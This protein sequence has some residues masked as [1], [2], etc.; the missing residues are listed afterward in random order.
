MYVEGGAGE[1]TSFKLQVGNVY[2]VTALADFGRGKCYFY[3]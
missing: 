2:G 3:N 1:E